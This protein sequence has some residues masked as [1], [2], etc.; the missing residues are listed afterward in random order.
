MSQPHLPYTPRAVDALQALLNSVAEAGEFTDD[1]IMVLTTLCGQ[2]G[3]LENTVVMGALRLLDM[4]DSVEKITAERS[5]RYLYKVRDI[6]MENMFY[7]CR[8][9]QR[10][11][12]CGKFLQV[13]SSDAIV[14]EHVLAAQLTGALGALKE[15]VVSDKDFLEHS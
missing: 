11:C 12:S 2:F 5:R 14:C 15:S 9:S 6:E 1:Y 3:D 13:L 8:P 4:S 7:V 10:Y